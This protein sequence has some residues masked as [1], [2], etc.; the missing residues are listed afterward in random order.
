MHTV[1]VVCFEG[2][3]SLES[4]EVRCKVYVKDISI[5]LHGSAVLFSHAD[6]TNHK[7]SLPKDTPISFLKRTEPLSSA[8]TLL[9]RYSIQSNWYILNINFASSFV[10]TTRAFLQPSLKYLQPDIIEIT[11]IIFCLDILEDINKN[12]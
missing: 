8:S 2:D 6:S 12:Y 9:D 4:P 5:G 3:A 1:I 11:F 10:K 7:E